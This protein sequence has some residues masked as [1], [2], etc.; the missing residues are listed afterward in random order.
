MNRRLAFGLLAL[1]AGAVPQLEE[2]ES[3][4]LPAVPVPMPRGEIVLE[5]RPQIATTRQERRRLARKSRR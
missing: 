3:L 5:R 1:A 4:R 2:P